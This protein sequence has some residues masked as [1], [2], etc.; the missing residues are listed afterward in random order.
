LNLRAALTR[1][2]ARFVTNAVVRYPRTWRLLRRPFHAR[3]QQLAPQWDRM[4]SADHLAP[5]ES[6]LDSVK[7]SPRR[8]LDIGTGTGD[9]AVAIARRFPKAEVIGVDLAENMVAEARRKTPL[10]LAS[11]VRFEAGD[12]ERL[13]F[14]DESLDLVTL[15]N[16]IPFFDELSR[17]VA[18]GGSVVFGASLGPATPIYVPPERLRTELERRGFV[19]FATFSVGPGTAFLARKGEAS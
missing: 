3:W 5:L 2:F 6:A 4:R 16:A 7:P 13:P 9:A 18:P 10:D 11:R 1:R 8:A 17:L 12:A 15:A 14:E 19:H